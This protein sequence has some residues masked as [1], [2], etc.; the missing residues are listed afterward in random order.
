M[1]SLP[2]TLQKSLRLIKQHANS[3]CLESI[4]QTEPVT[5]HSTSDTSIPKPTDNSQARKPLNRSLVSSTASR[6]PACDQHKTN[7]Q[8]VQPIVIDHH[9]ITPSSEQ[10]IPI[11]IAP[12]SAI[13]ITKQTSA[14]KHL[15]LN[16]QIAYSTDSKLPVKELLKCDHGNKHRA[17]L[18][19]HKQK[20]HSTEPHS[21]KCLE[22]MCHFQCR[23]LEELRRHLSQHHKYIMK[24]ERRKLYAH[25]DFKA[26]KES[27]E[28]NTNSWYVQTSGRKTL[29]DC[30]KTYYYCNRNG[31]FNS[32]GRGQGI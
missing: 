22:N 5:C 24:T 23:Y 12:Q 21:I 1:A 20:L 9:S 2:S 26:W 14:R 6:L 4:L 25:A 17:A 30:G 32:R 18:Y 31:H 11:S 28:K 29:L 7:P 10:A 15:K 19:K 27:L 3:H 13:A 8:S 16:K